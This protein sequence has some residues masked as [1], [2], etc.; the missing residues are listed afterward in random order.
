MNGAIPGGFL[1][2]DGGLRTIAKREGIVND[3]TDA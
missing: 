3:K 2:G 1:G